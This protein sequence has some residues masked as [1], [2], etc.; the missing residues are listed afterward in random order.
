MVGATLGVSLLGTVRDRAGL[1]WACH[2][3]ATSLFETSLFPLSPSW[4]PQTFI[5]HLLWGRHSIPDARDIQTSY[6]TV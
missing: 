6:F 3:T 1:M 4:S 2:W 5:E